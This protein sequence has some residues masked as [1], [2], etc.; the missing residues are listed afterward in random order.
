LDDNKRVITS[1]DIDHVAAAFRESAR[2]FEALTAEAGAVVAAARMIVEA[3]RGGGKAIFCGNGGSAADSQHLAA[4][5][6]GRYLKDREPLAAVA[7]TTD[8]SALTAIGNDYAF[9]EIFARQLRGL[10]RKG[11]VLIGIST[12]GNSR[13]VLAA[14]EAAKA[15]GIAT[16]AL[17]GAAGGAMR[18]LADL[19]IAVPSSDT[20]RV[21]EMHIA[22]GHMICD[23]VERAF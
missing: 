20:P 14:F 10:G 18:G 17:T 13:N 6:M 5:L 4:E 21:Q 23:L 22:V 16:I 19:C 1:P 11:D 12:S 9:D 2:N 15:R 8:S 7:L 3:L